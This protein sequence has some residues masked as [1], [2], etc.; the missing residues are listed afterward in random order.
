[1][2]YK[3]TV[4]DEFLNQSISRYDII[5]DSFLVWCYVNNLGT[6]PNTVHEVASQFEKGPLP[7]IVT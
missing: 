1:M 2:P 6:A 5:H 3:G 7:M 4:E